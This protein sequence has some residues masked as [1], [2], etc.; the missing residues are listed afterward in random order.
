[1]INTGVYTFNT[2]KK[3]FIKYKYGWDSQLMHLCGWVLSVNLSK[4]HFKELI[5]FCDSQTKKYIIDALD[6]PFDKVICDD[7]LP[8]I[9]DSLWAMPKLITYSKMNKPFIHI[10][11]DVFLF[12]NSFEIAGIQD[13]DLLVQSK[14]GEYLYKN[15]YEFG[16]K[17]MEDYKLAVPKYWDTT[18]K[19]SYNMGVFGGKDWKFIKQYSEEIL[20]CV[21]E[22]NWLEVPIE[23]H[24]KGVF[25]VIYEQY[26][27]GLKLAY[28]NKKVDLLLKRRIDLY[29]D[30]ESAEI[31]YSHLFSTAKL[32][33]RYS[34]QIINKVKNEY[35][36]EFEKINK[37]LQDAK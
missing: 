30:G 11:T 37:I 4:K 10:D 12:K 17:W 36:K 21:F 22:N 26:C 29:D 13:S 8:Q 3:S 35:P 16:V 34:F 6:L 20:K 15:G 33:S 25:N 32:N 31:G 19:Q 14:E 7:S 24:N 18:I 1:M 9:D 23:H 5:L 2:N 28:E 27:L